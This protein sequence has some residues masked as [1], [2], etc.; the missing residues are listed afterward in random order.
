MVI[1]LHQFAHRHHVL[2]VALLGDRQ[3]RVGPFEHVDEIGQHVLA[4]E[5]DERLR[6]PLGHDGKG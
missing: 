5:L 2:A 1:D 4:F 3:S 6:R